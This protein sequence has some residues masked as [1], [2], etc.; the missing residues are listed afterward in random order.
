MVQ[1]MIN[2]LSNGGN[3]L[4]HFLHQLVPQVIPQ[5]QSVLK[6][7][8]IL[9]Y[10]ILQQLS[11]EKLSAHAQFLLERLFSSRS[12]EQNAIL[13]RIRLQPKHNFKLA[14]AV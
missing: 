1:V 13:N 10:G 2:G 14:Y 11:E 5:V 7:R 8:M 3:G 4:Y 12:S 6:V 9:T